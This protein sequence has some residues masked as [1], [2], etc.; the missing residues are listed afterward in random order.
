MDLSFFDYGESQGE[1]YVLEDGALKD[2][3]VIVSIEA[4]DEEGT[5]FSADVARANGLYSFYFYGFA[6]EEVEAVLASLQ[7]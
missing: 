6:Q 3:D 1:Y 7:F 4:M 5:M 2:A